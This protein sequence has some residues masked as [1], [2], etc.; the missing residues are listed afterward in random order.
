MTAGY[1]GTIVGE[2]ERTKPVE[3]VEILYVFHENEAIVRYIHGGHVLKEG[4]TYN[5][6]YGELT[7][8]KAAIESARHAMKCFNITPESE[9]RVEVVLKVERSYR[10]KTGRKQ[11]F[12]P[13]EDEYEIVHGIGMSVDTISETVMWTSKEPD[14]EPRAI[15]VLE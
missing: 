7:C 12:R 14:A 5:D 13:D 6:Y 3:V 2:T 4:S 1:Q 8:L 11:Y 10:K 15:R 9:L